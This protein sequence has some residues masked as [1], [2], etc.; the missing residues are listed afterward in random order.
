MCDL[1]AF[2]PKPK[3]I[4][5]Y[6][7]AQEEY[8]SNDC[9]ASL[10]RHKS[11]FFFLQHVAMSLWPLSE[12][13]F[14]IGSKANSRAQNKNRKANCEMLTFFKSNKNAPWTSYMKQGAKLWEYTSAQNCHPSG[15]KPM[16]K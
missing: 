1:K 10:C 8:I 4:I 12:F 7:Y 16:N 6:R 9:Q 14:L 13:I 2:L 11:W 5:K 3:K 15:I